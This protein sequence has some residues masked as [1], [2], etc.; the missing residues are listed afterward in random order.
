MAR[1]VWNYNQVN[2]ISDTIEETFP[3]YQL[4]HRIL[5]NFLRSIFG[6]RDF[7]V[8]LRDDLYCMSLPRKLT[9]KERD[10]LQAIRDGDGDGRMYDS[11]STSSSSD[12]TSSSD[13]GANRETIKGAARRVNRKTST[14][15][16]EVHS[17]ARKLEITIPLIRHTENDH[18]DLPAHDNSKGKE[19]KDTTLSG[20]S[21]LRLES[22]GSYGFLYHEEI[23]SGLT[24]NV[25]KVDAQLIWASRTQADKRG[26][27]VSHLHTYKGR[28]VDSRPLIP[29][30]YI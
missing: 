7:H 9:L 27:K 28:R 21:H 4:P 12:S 8:T 19:L 13:Q 22:H 30:L 20:V 23:S 5:V 10:R 26:V 24:C 11:E 2:P 15:A 14:A 16:K 1:R 18:V 6:K 25:F 29:M 3:V 17:Q